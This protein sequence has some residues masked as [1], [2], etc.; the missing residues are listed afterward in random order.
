MPDPIFFAAHARRAAP[1]LAPLL[2]LAAIPALAQQV[3]EPL[4]EVVVSAERTLTLARSTPLSLGVV[5]AREIEAKGVRDLQ[6]VA[7]VV[8]GVSVPNGFSNMPQAVA[9]RG[10]G[11]SL[12]AMSQAVGIYLDDVPLVRGYATALWD[13]P[14]IERIEVL[15]GPQGTL[16]GQNSSGGA[17]KVITRAPTPE[18]EAWASAAAGNHGA[19]E[20]RA[21]L[22]GA[23]GAGG[24]AASLG[25]SRRRTDGYGYNAAL[26]EKVNRLDVA[27]VQ[28][29]LRWLGT[30]GLD[31]VLAVD[32]SRDRSDNNTINFPLNHPRAAPRVTFSG[33]GKD[34]FQRLAGGGSLRLV[35]Q[36]GG[37][38]ELRSITAYRRYR[39]DPMMADFGGLETPR[40]TIRQLVEQRAF[41][42][43]LQLQGR[44]ERLAWTTG[45]MLV[46]DDF[47]F[48]RF[49]ALHPL[50]APAPVHTDAAT[51]QETRDLGL[52]AQG[53]YALATGVG[54][55]LGARAYQTRQTGANAFWRADAGGRRLQQVYDAP[56]LA[57]RSRGVLPRLAL[58]W[59]AT[60]ATYLY[61]SYARGEKFGGFNRAA[62]SL[63][64]AHQATD[65]ERV[66]TFEAGAKGRYA[67]GRVSVD[68]ALFRNDYDDYLAPLSGTRI[69]GVQV[70]DVV[71]VNAAR[72]SSHGLDLDLGLALAQRTRWTVSLEAL[73][74]RFDDFINPGGVASGDYVGNEL[75][76]APRLSVA[77]SL[78][79][80]QPFASGGALTLD[81]SAKYVRRHYSEVS[82][83]AGVMIPD[84][85][86]VN[87]AAVYRTPS[88]RWSLALRARNLQ[89]RAYPTLRN[90]IAPLGIDAA[91]YNPPRTVLVTA[92]RDF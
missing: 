80:V 9:I 89:G 92:R 12:P 47:G 41:S 88:R 66:A 26:D 45:A 33:P 77:S 18:F 84:Q 55:T 28:A 36:L 53:R 67:G 79:H 87:L 75:P 58:D 54:L 20:A 34:A 72:A 35:K 68:L 60:P 86:Y 62:E 3:A 21:Y 6:D 56:D 73:R 5:E 29:K 10:V 63:V 25:V 37:G 49:T 65:P 30:A 8:A 44:G 32:G 50:A 74:S 90:R 27:Q 85:T 22:N 59:Q 39:D 70:S 83:A 4:P 51:R 31:A 48:T 40:M 23:L 2:A 52:Y 76:N 14:D 46:R 81:L 43:E 16:Y 57:T 7:N 78:S 38:A 82:N 11:A 71:L 15:R 17:V 13:L 61:A 1:G 24:L 42:Q 64:S 19:R 91:Y 69:D